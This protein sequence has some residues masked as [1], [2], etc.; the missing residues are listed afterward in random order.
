MGI[1]KG[2]AWLA[3]AVLLAV[4]IWASSHVGVMPALQDLLAR[5][6]EGYNPWFWAT[7]ADAYCGFLW[8]WLWVAYR[9]TGAAAKLVWLLVI[10][11]LG[12]MGM[13]AYVLLALRRLPA[14]AG[15]EQ[16]LLRRA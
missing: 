12:N 6:A 10:L 7:M 2:Y 13:A 9:E 15:V 16:L 3:L 5:P 14:G 4:S 8:F 1:V 11:A